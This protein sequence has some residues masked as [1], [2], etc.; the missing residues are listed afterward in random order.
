[1]ISGEKLTEKL[2]GLEA[3]TRDKQTSLVRK[4]FAWMVLFLALMISNMVAMMRW[5]FSAL[6]KKRI[7]SPPSPG[8]PIDVDSEEG[9][10][11]ILTDHDL[12]LA[13][14][15]AQWCGPCL[16]MTST[17]EAL[18]SEEKDRVVVARIDASFGHGLSE[19]YGVKGL[20]TFILFRNELEVTRK[21]GALTK[22]QLKELIASH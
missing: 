21:A 5:P 8:V 14:F 22:K 1:M 18:A 20:P 17:I 6:Q 16:L 19:K 3:L 13:E 2:N 12:V 4:L 15:W 10:L 9:F 11:R 7:T